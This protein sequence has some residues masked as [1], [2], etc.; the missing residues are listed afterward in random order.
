M[1]FIKSLY[2]VYGWQGFVAGQ[3]EAAGVAPVGRGRGLPH[4]GHSQLERAALQTLARTQLT[5]AAKL[6]APLWK[7]ILER[8]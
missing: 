8:A 1:L 6:V 7:C 5:P 2:A 4:A 3:R